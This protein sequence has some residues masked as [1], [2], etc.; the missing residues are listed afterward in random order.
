MKKTDIQI[1]S[2]LYGWLGIALFALLFDTVTIKHERQTLS[3][4]V[5]EAK[6]DPWRG[7]IA[8]AIWAALSYH[9]FLS[10]VPVVKVIHEEL[11]EL[12]D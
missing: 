9:L 6:Q 3:R 2:G 8:V 7:P 10:P 4:A 12:I 5:W 1:K 11:K